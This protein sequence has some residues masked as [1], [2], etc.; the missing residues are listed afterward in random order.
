MLDIQE[1]STLAD[2]FV[3]ASATSG[4]QLRALVE[5]VQEVRKS[6]GTPP[7]VE[8]DAESG[9][10]LVDHGDVVTHIFSKDRREFYSLE[11]V[12]RQARVVVRVQ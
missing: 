12:W 10:V 1:L 8:G 9:W 3:I 5:A 7:R 4:R 2:F 11:Q 6:N